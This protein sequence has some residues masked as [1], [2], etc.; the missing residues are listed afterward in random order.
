MQKRAARTYDAL[1]RAAAAEFDSRGYEGASLSRISKGASASMGAL[2]FHFPTKRHLADAVRAVGR[3]AVAVVTDGAEADRR[4]PLE[5]LEG[6]TLALVRL[7]EQD[8]VA[9]AAARLER[10][11]PC[12]DPRACPAG[13]W[14]HGV[15]VLLERAAVAGELRP[16][17]PP[18]TV[19]AL[20]TWLVAGSGA[21]CRAPAEEVWQVLL[22]GMSAIPPPPPPPA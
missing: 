21:A 22:H 18:D 8:V 5:A 4:A 12:G 7:L 6:L 16:G 17:V 9:R 3:D 13:E 10:D 11:G 20:L 2:T 14:T 15:R 19:V 1:I